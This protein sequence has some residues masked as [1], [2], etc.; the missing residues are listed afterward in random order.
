MHHIRLLSVRKPLQA[1][2]LSGVGSSATF[3]A[4]VLSLILANQQHLV[5][6]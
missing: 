5:P 2:R 6:S 4:V 3:E 1:Y